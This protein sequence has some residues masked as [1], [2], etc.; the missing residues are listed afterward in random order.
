MLNDDDDNSSETSNMHSYE[1]VKDD[2]FVCN[3][4][5]FSGNTEKMCTTYYLHNGKTIATNETV[6]L[7]PKVEGNLELTYCGS[8]CASLN[9]ADDQRLSAYKKNEDNQKNLFC[10]VTTNTD[11]VTITTAQMTESDGDSISSEEDDD[12]W[13]LN[14]VQTS[15]LENVEDVNKNVLIPDEDIYT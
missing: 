1:T 14:S 2:S 9:K 10:K 15:V 7:F 8:N 13:N 4:C 11:D 6:D 3:N 12:E 5:D